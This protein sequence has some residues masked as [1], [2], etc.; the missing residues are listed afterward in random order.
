M[1]SKFYCC[2]KSGHKPSTYRVKDKPKF[3]RIINKA[4]INNQSH[5]QANVLASNDHSVLIQPNR[6]M[7]VVNDNTISWI[8]VYLLL[9]F[10]PI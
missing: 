6:D 9:S 2:G 7:S 4:K 5:T 10:T 1:E 8:G 3:E